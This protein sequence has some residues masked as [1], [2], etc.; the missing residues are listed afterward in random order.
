M[1]NSAV[2]AKDE[3]RQVVAESFPKAAATAFHAGL[4]CRD[5]CLE[6]VAG[7]LHPEGPACPKCGTAIDSAAARK[8][9]QQFERLQCSD[10]GKWFT[11]TTGT[12]LVGA[13]LDPR[14]VFLLAALL[15]LCVDPDLVARAVGV[16]LV[17]VRYWRDKFRI[18]SEVADA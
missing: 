7:R 13:K 5:E 12:W 8:R 3:A 11:A 15:E 9:W 6:L 2:L 4:L 14:Q 1:N 18:L 17:T 10:C 16:S